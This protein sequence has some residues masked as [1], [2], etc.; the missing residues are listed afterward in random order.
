MRLDFARKRTKIRLYRFYWKNNEF[1]YFHD[2]ILAQFQALSKNYLDQKQADID[3]ANSNESD[4]DSE[5]DE[6][7]DDAKN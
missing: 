1:D 2:N 5:P 6:K 3:A 4:V 7:N